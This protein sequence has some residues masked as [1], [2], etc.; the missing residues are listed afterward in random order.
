MTLSQ[1][2]SYVDKHSSNSIQSAKPRAASNN[3]ANDPTHEKDGKKDFGESR[4]RQR[5][6]D[7]GHSITEVVTPRQT[8]HLGNA[9]VRQQ[10]TI[11]V[12]EVAATQPRGAARGDV[13]EKKQSDLQESTTM[14]LQ[15]TKAD[16]RETLRETNH[17]G[18]AEARQ[19][20]TMQD[21]IMAA[22]QGK[23]LPRGEETEKKP[24]D[25][26]ESATSHLQSASAVTREPLHE[27][28]HLENAEARHQNTIQNPGVAVTQAKLLPQGDVTEKNPCDLQ[29]SV[30]AHLQSVSADTRE[31]LRET[32]HFE[33]AEARQQNTIQDPDIAATHTESL[34][35]GEVTEKKPSHL[36]ESATTHLQADSAD[37]RET[38]RETSHLGNAEVKRQNAFQDLGVA[39]TQAKS[40]MPKGEVIERTQS[41]LEESTAT[42]LQSVSVDTQETLS[43]TS[44][45]GNAEARQQI[46]TQDPDIAAAHT[47]SLPRGD[48]TE[49]KPS[50]LEENTATHLQSVS[51]D[52]R[53]TLRETSHFESAE[54]RQQNTI[55]DPDIAATHTE[56][57]P[58]GEVTEKKPSHLLVEESATTHL[59]AD[60]T[61]ARET[62]R[63]TSHFGNAEAKRQNAIQELGVAATQANSSVPKGEVIEK[64]QSDLEESTA[65]HL[66]SVSVDIRETLS[67][68]SHLG[69]A[70]ARQQNTIQDSEVAAT[71]AKSLPREAATEKRQ[72]DR[73]ETATTDPHSAL[74]DA[75]ETLSQT[76][77]L[78]NAEARQQNNIQ[79]PDVA[80][81]EAARG[82]IT[83][84]KQ[85][86]A[87][88]TTGISV[89]QHENESKFSSHA[90]VQV[91][92]SFAAVEIDVCDSKENQDK[93]VT[94]QKTQAIVG[95][96]V[97]ESKFQD[98]TTYSEFLELELETEKS[99]KKSPNSDGQEAKISALTNTEHPEMPGDNNTTD[100]EDSAT[101]NRPKH[102]AFHNP[103]FDGEDNAENEEE[104]KG[105]RS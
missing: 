59:Q 92:D 55:Q 31:T 37:A 88:E 65:T 85:S 35:R 90:E 9:E 82:K 72:S 27:T 50:D 3:G 46:T 70:E 83:E 104:E 28:G 11:Q 42:H 17:F 67:E 61:D 58:R 103:L 19:Q 15:L 69:N 93:V 60:S 78:G 29:K 25:L 30:T 94:D 86:V 68:T 21:P 8:S 5:P 101:P 2:A 71:Q 96:G 97:T 73:Q 20:N 40:S 24:P 32:S 16:T 36:E 48:V 66:Q 63:E 47:E 75:Q 87:Q 51:V 10:N 57:L 74:A 98:N 102:K 12:P 76:G 79:D 13:T 4:S 62:L 39:A 77:H 43:E 53:E 80:A 7:T 89:V 99:T 84:K 6:V 54:A 44:H 26:H 91:K 14:H 22:T 38:L 100:E 81:T 18:N 52:T 49:N 34:P 45:L 105:R 23:S 95:N 1:S 33:S 64:T 56:S 41:D